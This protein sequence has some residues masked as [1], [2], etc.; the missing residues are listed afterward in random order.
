MRTTPLLVVR[1]GERYKLALERKRM[2]P[3]HFPTALLLSYHGLIFKS[4]CGADPLIHH[5]RHFG[6]AVHAMSNISALLNNGIIW[7][8]EQE[9]N[10]G[11]VLSCE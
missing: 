5:G 2:C 10:P 1:G 11:L 7:L 4:S 8:V 9:E 3:P 6:H